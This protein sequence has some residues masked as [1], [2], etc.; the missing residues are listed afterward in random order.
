MLQVNGDDRLCDPNLSMTKLLDLLY[1]RFC[2][3]STVT[4]W[5]LDRLRDAPSEHLTNAMSKYTQARLR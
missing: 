1:F 4:A 2:K 3:R 5:N